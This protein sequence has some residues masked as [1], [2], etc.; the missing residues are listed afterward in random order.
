M[1][2]CY[3]T[4]IIEV[5]ALRARSCSPM[6]ASQVRPGEWCRGRHGFL[7]DG[8]AAHAAA[9]L[10]S[11]GLPR[12]DHG[13][14]LQ[15]RNRGHPPVRLV[16]PHLPPTRPGS[17]TPAPPC[18]PPCHPTTLPPCHPATMP[19]CHH[20]TLPP[21]HHAMNRAA[22]CRQ[23]C[24]RTNLR[25]ATNPIRVPRCGTNNYIAFWCSVAGGNGHMPG[26]HIG[27][28]CETGTEWD[29]VAKLCQ[30]CHALL[31]R[32]HVLVCM[33]P[34]APKVRPDMPGHCLLHVRRHARCT[35]T[36]S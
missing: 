9:D 27:R 17:F 1:L 30:A 4:V 34:V 12:Q 21:C 23:A 13:Q 7:H 20:A 22:P 5:G 6:H 36:A 25:P 16:P 24:S 10:L 3:L 28:N 18:M 19:P 33:R 15:R 32:P 11:H 14:R 31:V 29:G 2:P 26:P 35:R 8:P